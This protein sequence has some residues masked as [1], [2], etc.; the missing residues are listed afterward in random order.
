MGIYLNPGKLLFKEAVSSDIY[1]DKSGLIEYTNNSIGK[2]QKLI[3]VSRPRR[4]G[5]S[6]TANMLVAYYEKSEDSHDIFD[7]LNIAQSPSYEKYINKFDV[8]FLNIQRFLSRSKNDADMIGYLQKRVID[9]LRDEFGEYIKDTDDSLIDVF[10]NLYA[11]TKKQFVFILDEWDCIFR[12]RKNDAGLQKDY[13]DFLRDLFKG[14]PYVSMVYMTGI[15]PI[16]KYGTHSALNMFDEYSMLDMSH[17]SE[18]TG[19]T[20]DEV[21][22]LCNKYSIDIDEMNRWYDGYK[23]NSSHIY[24][25]K[26]VVD[27]IRH[28]SFASYWTGTETYEAL[29]IYIDMD[30]DGLKAAVVRLLAG[31]SCKVNTV[32]F[33]ND[34]TTLKSKNDILTLLVHLGYLSYDKSNEA[35]FIPNEEIRR[36][37]VN[38]T[39]L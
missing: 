36:E 32:T 5:K 20:P 8:I 23:L 22:A 16:K 28:K 7:K 33:A 3:C 21:E 29:K 12:E 15:L 13:L 24:S 17:L 30:F 38:A 25:P 14:Q 26:S 6:I 31:E 10:E 2:E 19:F 34:M 4:F 39:E 18:Y 27:S 11:K 35:V 9:D 1:V 37:F